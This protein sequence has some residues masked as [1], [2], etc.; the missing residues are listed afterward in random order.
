M[1]LD[2]I[3]HP[4]PLDPARIDR[5]LCALAVIEGLDPV[6]ALSGSLPLLRDV[7]AGVALS[8]PSL[9][10]EPALPCY[11]FADC[12]TGTAAAS[13]TNVAPRARS[14]IRRASGRARYVL[15]GRRS[16]DPDGRI[17]RWRWT[18]GGRVIG[19]SV[20]VVRRIRSRSGRPVVVRLTVTD[21]DGATAV[22]RRRVRGR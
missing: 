6:A 22:S 11:A 16:T 5:G 7:V 3:E 17:V 8:T 2:A 9:R 12:P 19:R 1:V 21:E 15:D 13:P 10:S 18:A 4:G 20:R 14:R